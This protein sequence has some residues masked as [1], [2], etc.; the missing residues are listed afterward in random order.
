MEPINDILD[1][2][3]LAARLFIV[4][5]AIAVIVSAIA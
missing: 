3:I 5:T 2:V 1:A 4:F